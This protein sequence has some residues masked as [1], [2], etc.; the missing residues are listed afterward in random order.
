MYVGQSLALTLEFKRVVA[1]KSLSAFISQ[2]NRTTQS[3]NLQVIHE[4]AEQ[5]YR[6][7]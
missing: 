7:K 1:F 5:I 4:E 6:I 2:A 3:S